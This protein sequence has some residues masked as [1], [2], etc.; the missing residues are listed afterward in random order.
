ME[1]EWRKFQKV[2]QD[3][4][5]KM[6]EEWTIIKTPIDELWHTN[7]RR[8]L[9]LGDWAKKLNNK[10]GPEST[11][12]IM[13]SV[14]QS[15]E[16]LEEIVCYEEGLYVSILEE[17]RKILNVEHGL[18]FTFDEWEL[19]IGQWLRIYISN[20]HMRYL[21]ISCAL[22]KY[23]NIKTTALDPENYYVPQDTF[24][25]LGVEGEDLYNL[26]CYSNILNSIGIKSEFRKY[27]PLHKPYYRETINQ[28]KKY[29]LTRTIKAIAR[30]IK[31]KKIE[32]AGV[33][34]IARDYIIL[35]NTNFSR[36]N[37]K[38]LK[39]NADFEIAT[40]KFNKKAKVRSEYNKKK[41]KGFRLGTI[42]NDFEKVLCD[43]IFMDLPIAF[44]EGF[45][46][47]YNDVK[48]YNKLKPKLILTQGACGL[49]HSFAL[50]VVYRKRDGALL[51]GV[52]H[53]ANSGVY[54]CF[55][56]VEE[57]ASDYFVTWG[58]EGT[59]KLP[60]PSLKY[61]NISLRNIQE[62]D[63]ILIPQAYTRKYSN[64]IYSGFYYS[65]DFEI[66]NLFLDNLHSEKKKRVV[67]REYPDTLNSN[68]YNEIM[69]MFPELK[70]DNMSIPFIE[71]A[72][73]SKVVVV[74]YF[75]NTFMEALLMNRPTIIINDSSY[76]LL[77]DEFDQDFQRMLYS[78]L[79]VK[80]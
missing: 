10:T 77:R 46:E 3:N 12:E 39:R 19:L 37:I 20:Y 79:I 21:E 9:F 56:W 33:K 45:A 23:I 13:D 24:D 7:A 62:T 72:S 66:M 70:R 68:S 14:V 75:G 69:K 80:T 48:I 30:R 65:H 40:I 43:S 31:Q 5:E 22:K 42:K 55:D 61:S 50:W 54:S 1:R 58:W 6:K 78:G 11:V 52:Q 71:S 63:T 4:V 59:K 17:L 16:R 26:Q 67:Y 38:D 25:Y 28:I 73:R 47:I 29:P 64:S 35:A 36:E 49:Y 44:L 18:D 51:L 41:R 15:K 57:R 34:R 60:L 74:T 53:A 8:L 32:I 2:S 27:V 76:G